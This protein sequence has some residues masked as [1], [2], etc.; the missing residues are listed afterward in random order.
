MPVSRWGTSLGAHYR[1]E[2]LSFFDDIRCELRRVAAADI[3]DRVDIS[4]RDEQNVARLERHRRLRAGLS[5]V[6][7]EATTISAAGDRLA[8]YSA[9]CRR[10]STQSGRG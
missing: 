9:A 2:R 4:G 6:D 1:K 10:G 3:L 8:G 7:C 5:G